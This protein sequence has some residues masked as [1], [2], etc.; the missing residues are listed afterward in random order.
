[1]EQRKEKFLQVNIWMILVLAG[2]VIATCLVVLHEYVFGGRVMAF[3]DVGSD[4]IQQYVP[5]YSSIVNMLRNG[6]F[7]LWNSSEGFGINMFLL[8]MTNPA[9]MVIYALGYF[10][11]TEQM[12]YFLV[13]VYIGEILLA[14][15]SCYLFLSAFRL[16]ELPKAMASYMYAFNGFIIV[17]GQHYQFAIIPTL[18]MVELLLIERCIRFPKK[19]KLLTLHSFVI[20]LSSCYIAYMIFIFCGFYVVARLFILPLKSFFDYVKNVFRLAAAMLL[21]VGLGGIALMPFVEALM[22][23]SSRIQAEKSLLDRIFDTQYPEIYN[24]VIMGRIFSTTSRGISRYSGYLNYYEDPCLW[25]STLAVLL[26]AQ[27]IF[28]IPFISGARMKSDPESPVGTRGFR[29][30]RDIVQYLL[31]AVC[32]VSVTHAGIATIFNG[33]TAPFSRYLFLAFPYFAIVVAVTLN[34]IMRAKRVSIIGLVIGAAVCI[35]FYR[36]YQQHPE[37]FNIKMVSRIHMFTSLGMVLVLLL[38][39]LLRRVKAAQYLV[40]AALC[41]LLVFNETLDCYTDFLDRDSVWKDGPYYEVM[42]NPDVLAALDYLKSNDPEYYRLEKETSATLCMD[43]MVQDYHSISV[44]NSTMNANVQNYVANY[45]PEIVYPDRNHYMYIHDT[46]NEAQADLLGLKYVLSDEDASKFPGMEVLKEFGDI[47]ILA[48]PDVEN[49][50]SVY[51]E[52]ELKSA[53]SVAA[54]GNTVCVDVSYDKRNTD[55]EVSLIDSVNDNY[56]KGTVSCEKDSVVFIAAPFEYGW[57]AWVDGGQAE[58][59]LA[60]DGFIAISVPRGDH[61][62]ELKYSCPGIMQGIIV[63]GASALI[64]LLCLVI[65]IRRRYADHTV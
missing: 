22:H 61:D 11:G 7:A 49:I 25:F 40:P 44:Y 24:W 41:L 57:S 63:S 26:A 59:I 58:M 54:D 3:F 39:M 36:V 55:A 60:N 19:W 37:I 5:Q 35:R 43:S 38:I 9:L 32:F 64:F 65:G 13:Y 18:L 1:M 48:A 42:Y 45:W 33:F 47:K 17:W 50:C 34:E 46:A 8:N 21:G 14:G 28:L 30:K 56:F 62:F 51:D 20:M 4:T 2:A 27:Y 23:V 12:T 16:R 15:I 6:T 52:D 29:V 10:F 53:F 31:I